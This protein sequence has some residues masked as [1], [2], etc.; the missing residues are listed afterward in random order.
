M[1]PLKTL[2]ILSITVSFTS[3]WFKRFR[4]C[5]LILHGVGLDSQLSPHRSC[6]I[7]HFCATVVRTCTMTVTALKTILFTAVRYKLFRW[8]F[9]WGGDYLILKT[10][11]FSRVP[12]HLLFAVSSIYRKDYLQLSVCAAACVYVHN[13]CMCGLLSYVCV[14]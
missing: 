8:S 13:L 3:C 5:I 9:Q 12:V 14:A 4:V 11:T 1:I 10:H 2:C 6:C 7:I